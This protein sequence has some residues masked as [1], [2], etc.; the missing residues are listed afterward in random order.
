[1]SRAREAAVSLSLS[2]L[3]AFPRRSSSVSSSEWEA[4]E[5][6]A[7]SLRLSSACGYASSAR[8]SESSACTSDQRS[9]PSSYRCKRDLS[10]EGFRISLKRVLGSLTAGTH[11]Y[12]R[13]TRHNESGT[14][15]SPETG[16]SRRH[17][18]PL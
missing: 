11:A 16:P 10:E 13:Y 7:A 1:M 14:S 9:S 4:K 8:R 15:P 18:D 17:L 3:S 6:E 2:M 5:A 12:H